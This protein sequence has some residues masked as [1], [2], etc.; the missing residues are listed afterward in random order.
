MPGRMSIL[1]PTGHLGFTPIERGS[2]DLGVAQRP[3]AIVADSGSCDIG[4]QPLGADEHCSPEE[5]QR[6]DL[7]L[8]LVAA[9]GLGVPMI[10]G[11][12]SDAGTDRGVN[13][14]VEVIRKVAREHHPPR[15]RVAAIY[16]RMSHGGLSRRPGRAE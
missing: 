4:P 16:P 1:S 6:H 3:D 13:Q 9:R 5:W 14:Y 10:V 8:M 11:S 2:F 12:A 7:E 15:F